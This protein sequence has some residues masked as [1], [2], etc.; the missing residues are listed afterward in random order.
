MSIQHLD[1]K[2]LSKRSY[3]GLHVSNSPHFHYLSYIAIRVT[4]LVRLVIYCR[5]SIS[6]FEFCCT[7]L[8][9]THVLHTG[10]T[11]L[12]ACL[13]GAVNLPSPEAGACPEYCLADAYRQG[14]AGGSA[15]RKDLAHS[16]S[17]AAPPEGTYEEHLP[18]TGTVKRNLCSVSHYASLDDCLHQFEWLSV[19]MQNMYAMH[20]G[21][22]TTSFAPCTC[23]AESIATLS[24]GCLLAC[25]LHYCR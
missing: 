23:A 16:P 12:T 7:S 11:C 5:T 13:V 8:F 19:G 25:L 6:T 22:S 9:I 20:K 18:G 4:P 24:K 3:S 21:R 15:I 14:F 2:P 1:Y 10:C 17:E